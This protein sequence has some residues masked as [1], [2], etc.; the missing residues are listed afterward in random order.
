M[1]TNVQWQKADQGVP[2]EAG[3]G[4]RKGGRNGLP[5]GTRKLLGMMDMLIILIMVIVSWLYKQAKTYQ[6]VYFKYVFISHQLY[7]N[8]VTC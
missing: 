4:I 7:F 6:V 5:R 3:A 1:Q 8:K 2:K